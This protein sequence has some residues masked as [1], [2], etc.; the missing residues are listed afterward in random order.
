M[1]LAFWVSSH[2]NALRVVVMAVPLFYLLCPVN[3]ANEIMS[4]I[5]NTPPR[6]SNHNTLF[7][8]WNCAITLVFGIRKSLSSNKLNDYNLPR[9]LLLLIQ[10]HA[11]SGFSFF[12]YFLIQR[13]LS[14]RPSRWV[15]YAIVFVQ[16][17]SN[18]DFS[19]VSPASYSVIGSMLPILHSISSIDCQSLHH[20]IP[21]AL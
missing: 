16:K 18:I 1:S 5:S 17:T 2:V 9:T 15:L 19:W 8:S 11:S 21:K 3:I 6:P 4:I 14:L 13:S 20:Y 10:C 12:I 7:H